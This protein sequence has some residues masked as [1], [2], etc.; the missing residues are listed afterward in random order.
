MLSFRSNQFT[1]HRQMEILA[2]GYYTMPLSEKTRNDKILLINKKN[3][4]TKG[5]YM[6]MLSL[7]A[8]ATISSLSANSSAAQMT[9]IPTTPL[10]AAAPL[11]SRAA[12]PSTPAIATPS[13]K[14]VAAP[15]VKASGKQC[16]CK[17]EWD[18][19][20]IF[21]DARCSADT[22]VSVVLTD[23]KVDDSVECAGKSDETCVP[24][25]SGTIYPGMFLLETRYVPLP[26]PATPGEEE[27]T[28]FR[29]VMMCRQITSPFDAARVRTT[30][31]ALE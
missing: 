3:L 7:L 29:I 8:L 13:V 23:R 24:Y 22:K 27:V 28:P 11:Q 30:N 1:A 21:F 12:A 31:C 4:I 6:R 2:A 15:P 9:S 20:P 26:P 16:K 17:C 14:A 5:S 25:N 19:D 18:D 10:V